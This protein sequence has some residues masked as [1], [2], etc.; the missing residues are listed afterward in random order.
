[1]LVLLLVLV[2]LVLLVEFAQYTEDGRTRTEYLQFEYNE[3]ASMYCTVLYY[4]Y[5]VL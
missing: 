5:A 2:I 1:M 3:S 4:S